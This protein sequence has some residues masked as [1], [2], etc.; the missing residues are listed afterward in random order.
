MSTAVENENKIDILNASFYK[1]MELQRIENGDHNNILAHAKRCN[2]GFST[3]SKNIH[4]IF[5][6][7]R[8]WIH[9]QPGKAVEF[10]VE[11]SEN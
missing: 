11:L 10:R 5:P 6:S 4:S 9:Q 8:V 3:F 7:A 1:L 2:V